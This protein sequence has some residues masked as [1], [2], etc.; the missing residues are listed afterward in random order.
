MAALVQGMRH[1]SLDGNFKE[2]CYLEELVFEC[3]AGVKHVFYRIPLLIWRYELV[4]LLFNVCIQRLSVVLVERDD[5]KNVLEI[6]S[7][8]K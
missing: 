8:R 3:R 6:T 7:N 2:S 1:R 4:S 5:L